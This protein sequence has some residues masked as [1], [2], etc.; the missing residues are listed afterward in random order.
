MAGDTA[1]LSLNSRGEISVLRDSD[2]SGA[3]PIHHELIPAW[4]AFFRTPTFGHGFSKNE[5]VHVCP[6]AR[7]RNDLD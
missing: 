3:A 2:H 1:G 7:V 6:T 4:G 5:W